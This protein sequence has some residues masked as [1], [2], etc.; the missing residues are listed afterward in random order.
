MIVGFATGVPLEGL[1]RRLFDWMSDA[2]FPPQFV[3]ITNPAYATDPSF[4][5]LGQVH[6]CPGINSPEATNF[7]VQEK[8]RCV[9]VFGCGIVNRRTAE[10][11]DGMLINAHSG[12]LPEYRGVNNVEWAYLERKP[13]V[14]TV[15]FIEPNVDS[16][17][18]ILEREQEKL[19]RAET[20]DE[21]RTHA[22]EQTF[23]LIP[24]ALKRIALDEP[25][26]RQPLTPRTN[27]YVMHP[28]LKQQV[29]LPRLRAGK[30]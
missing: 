29:L 6:V 22:F 30:V 14:G 26:R 3:L 1:A 23:Q 16:G 15:H 19:P 12:Q 17:P 7:I 2:G 18:V 11:F 13:V 21:I 25:V 4:A 27:R 10:R 8:P 24:Q 20:I 5:G 28:F 9:V